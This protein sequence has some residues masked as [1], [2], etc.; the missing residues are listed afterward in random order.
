MTLEELEAAL[1]DRPAPL[2]WGTERSIRWGQ[3]RN[4]CPQC[5]TRDKL[6]RRNYNM[7]WG[8]ADLYCGKCD[9]KIRSMDFG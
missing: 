4:T 9:I 3:A 7:M 6:E 8:D 2:E 1:A 5:L